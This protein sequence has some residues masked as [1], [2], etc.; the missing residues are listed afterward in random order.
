[1]AAISPAIQINGS[2]V[3]LE[4]FFKVSKDGVGVESDSNTFSHRF[5]PETES[6]A[7]WG[8]LSQSQAS[9]DII[10]QAS[11]WVNGMRDAGFDV[12]C[13]DDAGIGY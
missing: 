2:E 5:Y 11:S 1:M 8:R 10:I 7:S 6:D 12:N 3:S 4:V 9:N 13:W